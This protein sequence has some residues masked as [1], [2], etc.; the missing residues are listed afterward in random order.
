MYTHAQHLTGGKYM[1]QED[2]FEL[3]VD[4]SL[5]FGDRRKCVGIVIIEDTVPE[6]DEFFLV[7]IEGLGVSTTVIILD[8]DGQC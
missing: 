2:Y 3:D 5:Q 8:D 4:L 1:G 7:V 6:P